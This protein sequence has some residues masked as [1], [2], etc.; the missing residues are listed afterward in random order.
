LFVAV[1]RASAL[2]CP[3]TDSTGTFELDAEFV[4]LDAGKVTLKRAL[5]PRFKYRSSG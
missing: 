4:A 5:A 2:G 3:W 1:A